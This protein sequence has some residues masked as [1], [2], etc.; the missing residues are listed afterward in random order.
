MSHLNHNKKHPMVMPDGTIIEQVVHLKEVI[1][2]PSIEIGEF[3]YYHNFDILENYESYLAPYLFPLSPDKLIIGKFVQIA[4]GVRFITN[5]ANHKM[6]AFSTYPFMNFMMTNKTTS[7]DIVK[8]FEE[9]QNAGDTVVGNDVWIGIDATIMP[10]VKIG[11]GAIIGAKSVV[12]KN[13]EP[14]TIV[15]GNPA[16]VIKRRFDDDTV[17]KLL[18]IKWWEWDIKTIEKNIGAIT[19]NDIEALSDIANFC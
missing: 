1:D 8:M 7:E 14:Y 2:H 3:S 12:T 16:K 15:A 11:D 9:S 13:V 10:N 17:E 5:S 19:G 6:K 4:H 18:K